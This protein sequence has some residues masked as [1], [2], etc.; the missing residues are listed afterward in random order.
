TAVPVRLKCRF[1]LAA[2]IPY[3]NS[4]VIEPLCDDPVP[5][6]RNTDMAHFVRGASVDYRRRDGRAGVRIPNA[7]GVSTA[8]R[9][10]FAIRRGR[11]EDSRSHV[12]SANRLPALRIGPLQTLSA[13]HEHGRIVLG[14]PDPLGIVD[15]R[16]R[17]VF[18]RLARINA[19]EV[20]TLRPLEAEDGESLSTPIEVHTNAER[21]LGLE[22]DRC[23]V[24]GQVPDNHPV[25]EVRH[26]QPFTIAAE[27]QIRGVGITEVR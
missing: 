20:N 12:L 22:A 15:F 13:A 6:G 9:N 24:R 19:N 8:G 27:Y 3:A 7:D 21:A 25:C 10:Q 23:A 17:P 18:A 16:Y 11:R 2:G 4:P 5:I 1:D 14:E 26:S